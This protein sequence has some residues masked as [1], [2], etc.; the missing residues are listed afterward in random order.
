MSK[1][2]LA[3]VLVLLAG[4]G[5]TSLGIAQVFTSDPVCFGG[6]ACIQTWNTCECADCQRLGD[7]SFLVT[8]CG[9]VTVFHSE[10]MISKPPTQ[11]HCLEFVVYNGCGP[12][13]EGFC[14]NGVY[15]PAGNIG[16][17]DLSDCTWHSGACP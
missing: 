15:M 7:T 17:C 5:T 4:F 11:G 2:Q 16:Y 1:I 8:C 14:V 12:K 13:T 3:M 9:A 6:R 10:C